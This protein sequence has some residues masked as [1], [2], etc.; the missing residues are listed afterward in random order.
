MSVKDQSNK[1]C[2]TLEALLDVQLRCQVKK[3]VNSMRCQVKAVNLIFTSTITYDR[4][5][6]ALNN[7]LI[8]RV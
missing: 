5:L 7:I 1:I 8:G 4:H 6:L 3:A 2:E